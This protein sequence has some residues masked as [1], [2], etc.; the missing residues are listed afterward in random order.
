MNHT[1]ETLG[2]SI[3]ADERKGTEMNIGIGSEV[4]ILKN[5]K[6][7]RVL[8]SYQENDK[9]VYAIECVVMKKYRKNFQQFKQKF[10][11]TAEELE[12]YMEGGIWNANRY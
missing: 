4:T 12:L 5:G 8:D 3:T 7:G 2:A 11:C 1:K 10:Q 6:H 9:T